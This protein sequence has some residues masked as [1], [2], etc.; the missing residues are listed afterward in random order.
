M[1]GLSEGGLPAFNQEELDARTEAVSLSDGR[2]VSYLECGDPDGQPLLYC[3]GTP[4]CRYE[5]WFLDNSA[6]HHGYR[7]IA[8]D[9]PGMGRSDF[10]RGYTLLDYTS[11]ICELMD[12]LDI[13]RFG[14]V[15]LSGGGTTAMSCGVAL[16]ERVTSLGLV[17]SWAPV[18]TE[19]RLAERLAPMDRAF[20]RLTPLGPLPYLPA[21][22]LIGLAARHTSPETFALR[23]LSG[24]LSDADRRALEDPDV[25]RLMAENTREAFQS[26]FRG[27][28]RDSY[29]RY[30]DW[31]F[32]I[33]DIGCPVAVH[34]GTDDRFAPYPFGEYLTERI[35]G[36]TLH[37]YSGSGHLDFFAD[38]KPVLESMNSHVQ[39]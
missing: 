4:G 13:G 2:V 24:S 5:G 1:S 15:G 33:A 22:G 23:L 35:P 28:A 26:G 37:T 38:L 6:R 36:A 19:P 29:L 27:A 21:I 32:D 12:R 31:G 14:V 34:H 30:R 39:S 20:M 11:D 7:I 18:G 10:L 16:P 8:P 9:R 17:C 25:Q 3:H